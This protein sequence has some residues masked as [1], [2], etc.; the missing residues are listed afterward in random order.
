M[1][2]ISEQMREGMEYL[3][4]RNQA[5]KFIVY[6]QPFTN[7]HA[8]LEKLIPLYES[9]FSHPDVVGISIGTRPDA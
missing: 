3:R 1:K 6:F 2:S 4:R 5:E 9:A 7:T 8:P